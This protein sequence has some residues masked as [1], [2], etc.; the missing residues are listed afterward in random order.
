MIDIEAFTFSSFVSPAGAKIVGVSPSSMTKADLIKDLGAGLGVPDYFG[1]NWDAL[2][3]SLRDL[4]WV[5]EHWVVIKHTTLPRVPVDVL[6]MY[7]DVLARAVKSW[8]NS[9]EH[10]VVVTFP[11]AVREEVTLAVQG[12]VPGIDR[13]KPS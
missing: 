12:P 4:G 7:L 10:E 6:R 3:E 1:A 11:P 5:T 8:R 9:Q 13:D 2:D